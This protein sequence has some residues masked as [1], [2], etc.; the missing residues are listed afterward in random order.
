MNGIV[1]ITINPTI[2]SLT[3]KSLP[4]KVNIKVSSCGSRGLGIRWYSQNPNIAT[5]DSATGEITAKKV[6]ITEIY[7]FPQDGDYCYAKLIVV[8]ESKLKRFLK[9]V[10]A[11]SVDKLINLS[12]SIFKKGV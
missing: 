7:V 10:I 5:V 6:G 4:Y 8:V 3:T 2:I 12:K 9:T 1:S 11:N